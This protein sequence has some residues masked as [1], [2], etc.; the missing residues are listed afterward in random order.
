MSVNADNNLG[1]AVE[2]R[3]TEQGALITVCDR[4]LQASCWQGEFY[5]D[6]Y[7]TAGTTRKTRTELAALG[8]ENP[9]YWKTDEQLAAM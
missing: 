7:K 4:C 1:G 5:C 9:S 2:D 3:K 6:D 8:L